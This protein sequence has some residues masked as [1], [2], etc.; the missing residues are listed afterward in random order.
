MCILYFIWFVTTCVCIFYEE[1]VCICYE[2]GI[3]IYICHEVG[4]CICYEV[5]ICI[6]YEVGICI[7]ICHEV[8][9]CIC[10]EVGTCIC[11]KV[12]ICICICCEEGTCVISCIFFQ[13]GS[14]GAT[15]N[16]LLVL[17]E[18]LSARWKVAFITFCT[19]HYGRQLA[20][21]L[22]WNQSN[23]FQ[24]GSVEGVVTPLWFQSCWPAP[25]FSCSTS[26]PLPSYLYPQVSISRVPTHNSI[27]TFYLSTL[28]RPL[29]CTFFHLSSLSPAHHLPLPR[30]CTCLSA[31]QGYKRC[32]PLAKS[33][34]MDPL[35]S[36]SSPFPMPRL[37][38]FNHL[39]CLFLL[40]F[41][42]DLWAG[43]RTRGDGGNHRHSSDWWD[44][45]WVL[46]FSKCINLN[47]TRR[48]QRSC[49]A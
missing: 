30:P 41:P 35:Q 21:C 37:T 31:R 8:G 28:C 12:G 34:R 33:G 9:I 14:G 18:H 20:D 6:C 27:S 45:T 17:T 42:N 43:E 3:C 10:Y 19:L 49:S 25:R 40:H 23:C 36:T 11:Y 38:I 47:V 48:L 22:N 39:S 7:C 13:V 5:G 4:I 1:E 26:G 46:K 24:P 2:V 16:A 32:V 29:L 15:L 44:W